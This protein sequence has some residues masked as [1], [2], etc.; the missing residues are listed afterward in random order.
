MLYS[1]LHYPKRM[2]GDKEIAHLKNTVMNLRQTVKD[3][4]WIDAFSQYNQ[5][6]IGKKLTMNCR[7]CYYTVMMYFMNKK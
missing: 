7:K 3:P 5:E 2:V 1:I 6:N 4:I